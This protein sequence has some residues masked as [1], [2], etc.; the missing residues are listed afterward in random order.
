MHNFESSSDDSTIIE[1]FFNLIRSRVS[2]YVEV[3]R[4][5]TEEKVAD[6][7]S[8]NISLEA[9]FIQSVDNFDRVLI[10]HVF[11]NQMS[12]PVVTFAVRVRENILN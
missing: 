2:D 12:I 8:D 1:D 7:P 6:S 3:F 4:L 5:S 10:Y 11:T 9:E